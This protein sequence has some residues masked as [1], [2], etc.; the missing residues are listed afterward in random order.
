M[1][2]RPI[3]TGI[4]I[5]VLTV[6]VSLHGLGVEGGH[7][8]E[9]FSQAVQ[10]V[11]GQVDLVPNLQRP[12]RPNL[13]LPLPWHHLSI[14]TCHHTTQ[15]SDSGLTVWMTP[16]GQQLHN[17]PMHV[18]H[19]AAHLQRS[20]KKNVRVP[21]P[22]HHLSIDAFAHTQNLSNGQEKPSS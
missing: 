6:P 5:E 20:H 22:W 18:G 3:K 10:Q 13:E 2:N 8:V 19:P 7:N 11:A 1:Y 15:A 17:I 9:I 14:D 21:L 4:K 16:R 12:H